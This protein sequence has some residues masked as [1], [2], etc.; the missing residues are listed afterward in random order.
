LPYPGLFPRITLE[1]FEDSGHELF[2]SM[3]YRSL[4]ELFPT[5]LPLSKAGH[6]FQLTP[7][8]RSKALHRT[9]AEQL[10]IEQMIMISHQHECMKPQA[11]P[12]THTLEQFQEMLVC[13]I[14]RKLAVGHRFHD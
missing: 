8:G 13:A 6:F 7:V 10:T 14:V 4:Y 11:K 12:R 9:A 2:S 5:L 3:Q 1:F